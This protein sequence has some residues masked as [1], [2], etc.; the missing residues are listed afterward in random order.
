MQHVNSC[1]RRKGMNA[2]TRHAMFK[3][4]VKEVCHE[5]R[6]PV[7]AEEPRE[8]SSLRCPGC[9][10]HFGA[11]DIN[12]HVLQCADIPANKRRAVNPYRSGPDI[13]MNLGGATVVVDV[14]FVNPLCHAYKTSQRNTIFAA[15]A[16]DKR[17]L[18]GHRVEKQGEELVIA[19]ITPQGELAKETRDLAKRMAHAGNVAPRAVYSKF[20]MLA[21]SASAAVL[22][23]AERSH[24][25][26]ANA[27]A[28]AKVPVQ[29]NDSISS[30]AEDESDDP[31][32]SAEANGSWSRAD[33]SF[34]PTNPAF[35]GKHQ[36]TT[37]GQGPR[38]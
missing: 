14:T 7:S 24:R 32:T 20:A 37:G 11:D 35:A 36:Q 30:E 22:A 27:R 10:A 25:I 38:A 6:V 21:V 9:Q 2:S 34:A 4:V 29:A 18:Y 28:Y 1:P 19:S 23:A 17:R 13:R 15:R 12:S 8:Y 5:C 3:D 33:A 16:A 31:E 26:A